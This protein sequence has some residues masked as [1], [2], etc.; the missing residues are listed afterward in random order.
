VRRQAVVRFL[1]TSNGAGIIPR[2]R[3]SRDEAIKSK[4]SSKAQSAKS[5]K[6]QSVKGSEAQRVKGFE[7][8]SVKG[9]EA[10][11]SWVGF[12]ATEKANTGR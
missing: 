6:A 12:G 9:S 5:S 4:Q 10:Q 11:A 7:A 3:R 1:A 2:C 8:Q